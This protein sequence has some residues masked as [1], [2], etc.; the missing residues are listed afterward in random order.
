VQNSTFIPPVKKWHTDTFICRYKCIV[1]AHN[2]L[3][4]L[5]VLYS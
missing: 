4:T 3:D 5:P 2:D 1:P